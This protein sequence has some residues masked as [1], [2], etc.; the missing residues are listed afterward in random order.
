MTL[1]AEK[2]NWILAGTQAGS[3]W[4][5]HTQ[6]EK[7]KHQ[8]QKMSDSVTCLYC[9]SFAKQRYYNVSLWI[10]CCKLSLVR[11]D[12]QNSTKIYITL[13]KMLYV[14]TLLLMHKTLSTSWFCVF[15]VLSDAFISV[16]YFYTST[17]CFSKN[18]FF[19]G[20]AN[21]Q[22]AVF[23]DRAIKVQ[24]QLFLSVLIW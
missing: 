5:F 3:L 24:M 14:D 7:Y 8:L 4:A 19:V 1:P 2:E 9:N 21:G 16:T 13:H 10:K 15:I 12:C 20:T 17:F 23:E 22:L 6:D 11:S 18:F